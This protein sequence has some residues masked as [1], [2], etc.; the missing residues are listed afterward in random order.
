MS[1]AKDLEPC[2]VKVS[3]CSCSLGLTFKPIDL[4]LNTA[5]HHKKLKSIHESLRER[6]LAEFRKMFGTKV[7]TSKVYSSRYYL[8]EGTV[9][10]IIILRSD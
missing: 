3:Y 9:E 5:A 8:K 2:N 10:F 6:A 7:D 1:V 4:D